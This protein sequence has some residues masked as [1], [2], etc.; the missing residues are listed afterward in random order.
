MAVWRLKAGVHCALKAQ[1]FLVHFVAISKQE[2]S[3]C[4][5]ASQATDC[6]S[7]PWLP[8]QMLI[9]WARLC[10][11]AIDKIVANLPPK[12]TRQTLLFSAT[13]PADIKQLSDRALR[14]GYVIVDA[15]GENE[16][17]TAERVR[18]LDSLKSE[19][20]CPGSYCGSLLASLECTVK[21]EL[22]MFVSHQLMQKFWL[23]GKDQPGCEPCR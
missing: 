6:S 18:P 10:R 12:S 7:L 9:M 22:A 11:P 17:Q 8:L 15:I 20:A 13:F 4:L 19:A 16:E 23:L 14:P 3:R 5:Y 1:D 2:R 21:I